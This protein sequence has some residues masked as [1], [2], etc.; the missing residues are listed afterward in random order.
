MNPIERAMNATR[1]S[2][3]NLAGVCVVVDRFGSKSEYITATV[4]NT[5]FVEQLGDGS[6]FASRSRDYCIDVTAYALNG[7]VTEPE[8]GDIIC[9]MIGNKQCKFEVLSFDGGQA[10]SF[11]DR[12]R[13]VYRIHTKEINNSY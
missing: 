1:A 10:F 4:A 8:H 3:K 13:N 6:G 7:T 11:M 5:T 12:S 9:E 2:E